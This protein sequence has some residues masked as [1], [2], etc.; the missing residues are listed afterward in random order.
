MPNVFIK[1]IR[2]AKINCNRLFYGTMVRH[3]CASYK[4]PLWVNGKTKV[5]SRTKLGKNVHF[6]G[7]T[8]RGGGNV[9]IGDNFH[10]GENCL[11]ITSIHNYEGEAL[12]YD[13]TY[14]H[15]DIQVEDNV[16]LGSRVIVLG[17]VTIGEGAIIQAGSVVTSDIPACGIAGGHPA[18]LF[19]S[20]DKDHYYRLKSE[21]KFQQYG[22]YKE[23]RK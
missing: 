21:G 12:P 6:N 1:K 22:R 4:D 19:K 17:G 13:T 11:F 5:T 9:N 16:W 8:V 2:R 20:R 3:K 23:E 10:S 14:I 18:E 15:R 7:M